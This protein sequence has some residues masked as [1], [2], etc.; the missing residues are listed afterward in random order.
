MVSGQ[1]F[2]DPGD[3]NL[4]TSLQC[5]QHTRRP[6]DS[7]VV[8]AI[9]PF[10]CQGDDPNNRVLRRTAL[11]SARCNATHHRVCPIVL[12]CPLAYV[13]ASTLATSTTCLAT[14][15]NGTDVRR[16]VRVHRCIT[17]F[18]NPTRTPGRDRRHARA[19]FVRNSIQAL[20]LGEFCRV[21][22]RARSRLYQHKLAVRSLDSRS[23]SVGPIQSQVNRL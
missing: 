12:A 2:S 18:A 22:P 13:S 5:T 6:R 16:N 11:L 14:G 21:G 23:S 17:S 4:I 19:C 20:R 7:T 15:H 3:L 1:E 9:L 8:V 10:A